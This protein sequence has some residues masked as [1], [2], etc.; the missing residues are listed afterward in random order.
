MKGKKSHY[1]KQWADFV[2]G[3]LWL[4]EAYKFQNFG[5]V[6][7]FAARSAAALIKKG[8]FNRSFFIP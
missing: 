7:I 2:Q 5:S 1:W 4:A 6:L 8:L 3:A